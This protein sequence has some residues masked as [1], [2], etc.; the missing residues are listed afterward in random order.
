MCRIHRPPRLEKQRIDVNHI[1]PSPTLHDN[2]LGLKPRVYRQNSSSP[3]IC[4][5]LFT[6]LEHLNL[7]C[8]TIA[9]SLPTE[10]L[11]QVGGEFH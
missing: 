3:Q 10:I 4:F 11:L 7:Q 1:N 6:R 9:F 5:H 8:I 2:I